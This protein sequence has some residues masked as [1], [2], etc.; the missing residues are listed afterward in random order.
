MGGE[1]S[2]S[3]LLSSADSRARD[4]LESSHARK[5]LGQVKRE[6]EGGREFLGVVGGRHKLSSLL[7]ERMKFKLENE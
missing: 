4:V 1:S 7:P 6:E 2:D 3:F 5:Q